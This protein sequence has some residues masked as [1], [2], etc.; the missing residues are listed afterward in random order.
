MMIKLQIRFN[1]RRDRRDRKNTTGT[2]DITLFLFIGVAFQGYNHHWK[3]SRRFTLQTLRDFGVGKHSIEQ[4][5]LVEINAA[6]KVLQSANG[7]PMSITPL[8]QNIVGNITFGVVFGQRY[9][10]VQS[11]LCCEV[12]VYHKLLI[13]QTKLSSFTES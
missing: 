5:I 9:I 2:Y 10:H 4:K 6:S 13:S 7:Q 3:I 12:E 1:S 8:L 11:T